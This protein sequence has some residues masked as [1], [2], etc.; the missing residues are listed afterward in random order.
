MKH[1]LIILLFAL[2]VNSIHA[3]SLSL[4]GAMKFEYKLPKHFKQIT[5]IDKKNNSLYSFISTPTIKIKIYRIFL[6]A[7]TVKNNAELDALYAKPFER[8]RKISVTEKI[9]IQRFAG[10]TSCFASIT[11]KNY[12]VE[13][14]KSGKDWQCATI[15]I[16]AYK[17]GFIGF[18]ILS[19]TLKSTEYLSALKMINDANILK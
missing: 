18:W 17:H 6:S 4:L 1:A 7:N 16:I 11:D 9:K 13:K 12:G 10:K 8:L 14:S 5:E 2:N 3:E 19:D 15:G